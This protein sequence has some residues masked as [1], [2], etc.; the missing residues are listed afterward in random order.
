MRM[1]KECHK[2]GQRV[3]IREQ[4]DTRKGRQSQL[5]NYKENVC[6]IQAA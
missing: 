4:M 5:G 1:L 2:Q 3:F 6:C